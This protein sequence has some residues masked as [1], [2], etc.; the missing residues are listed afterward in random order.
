MHDPGSDEQGLNMEMPR[1][2]CC[3]ACLAGIA[4]AQRG[5]VGD[6]WSSRVKCGEMCRV[7]D[8]ERYGDG[9]EGASRCGRIQ[10]LFEICQRVQGESLRDETSGVT[11]ARRDRRRGNLLN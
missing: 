10:K 8:R 4:E 3:S 1:R 2:Q 7:E 6:V 5:S 9:A 11:G